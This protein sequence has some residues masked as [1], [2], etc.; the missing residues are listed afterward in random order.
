MRAHAPQR[1][2]VSLRGADATSLVHAARLAWSSPNEYAKRAII[3]AVAEA[4]QRVAT[5]KPA[6][7]PP[8][9]AGRPK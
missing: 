5:D 3:K 1:I 9:M 7:K 6:L 8:Q 2:H 4:L